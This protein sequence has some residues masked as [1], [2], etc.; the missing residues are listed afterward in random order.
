METQKVLFRVLGMV[1]FLAVILLGLRFCDT[2][3]FQRH[4]ILRGDGNVVRKEMQVKAPFTAIEIGGSVNAYIRQGAPARIEV[5]ADSNLIDYLIIDFDDETM[6]IR[7]K[8]NLHLSAP[9]KLL[10]T[11]PDLHLIRVEG[12]AEIHIPDTFSTERFTLDIRG[13]AKA[14]LLMNC[15]DF[16]SI[17]SGAGE[18]RLKGLANRS[19]SHINGAGKLVA[20]K[21]RV[22]SQEV[23]INGAGSAKVL[24]TDTL[25]ATINGAGSL[26][27]YGNPHLIPEINGVGRIRPGNNGS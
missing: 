5:M 13:A 26:E 4:K 21:F 10:I 22:G 1:V 23:K 17:I 11:T 7:Q 19:T 2:M 6:R 27:Y 25:K 15:H 3:I 8:K 12:A 20:E 18:I 14:Q 9:V 16:N 24:V